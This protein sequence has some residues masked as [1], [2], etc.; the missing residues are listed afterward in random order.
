MFSLISIIFLVKSSFEINPTCR[1]KTLS[2]LSHKRRTGIFLILY[3]SQ[4][5]SSSSA[6][7]SIIGTR[8]KFFFFFFNCL[9]GPHYSAPTLYITVTIK[10]FPN[11]LDYKEV[12]DFSTSLLLYLDHQK[13]QERY[14]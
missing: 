10:N 5:S 14:I 9:Q 2:L 12:Q 6:L 13:L 4:N 3:F 8:L 1:Y 11:K 7:I